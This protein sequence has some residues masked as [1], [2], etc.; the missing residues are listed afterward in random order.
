MCH[1]ARLLA[2]P[3]ARDLPVPPLASRGRSQG[4]LAD[5]RQA[6]PIDQRGRQRA[7][8]LLADLELL[9]RVE[10]QLAPIGA[11]D[12]LAASTRSPAACSARAC[13]VRIR[14]PRSK[15]THVAPF[16]EVCSPVI[17]RPWV[18]PGPPRRVSHS[19]RKREVRGAGEAKRELE[20]GRR[21]GGGRNDAG[22][23]VM[24]TR[25]HPEVP[26]HVETRRGYERAE[27]GEELVR[28]HVGVGDTAAPG[29]LEEDA[30]PAVGECLHGVM[31]E[32][33]PQHV[34]AYSLELAA[35]A[36][37]D[38]RRG[39]QVHVEGGDRQ[40]RPGRGLGR[41]DR[42]RAGEGELHARGERRVHVEVVVLGDSGDGLVDLREPASAPSSTMTST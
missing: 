30:D 17:G 3:A 14:Q 36:A 22:A 29:R 27:P 18:P 2:R 5:Q 38:G 20:H 24:V 11:G 8:G 34:A 28:G 23:Q 12:E 1:K 16:A 32:G 26:D 15:S 19:P 6:G 39:V 25:E 37:V 4:P 42:V 41:W 7:R 33:R 31:G 10:P 13:G 9:R 35:V 21:D 40:R